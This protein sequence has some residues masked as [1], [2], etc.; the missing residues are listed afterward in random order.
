MEEIKEKVEQVLNKIKKDDKFASKFKKDPV[1]AVE[2]VLGVDLPD[3]MI[4]KVIDTVKAKLTMDTAE[5]ALNKMKDLFG[6]K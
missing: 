6:K 5:D 3:E 1:K 2:D 4:N